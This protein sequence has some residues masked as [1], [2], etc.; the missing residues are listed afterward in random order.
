LKFGDNKLYEDYQNVISV[1]E[2]IYMSIHNYLMAKGKMP[3]FIFINPESKVRLDMFEDRVGLEIKK[4]IP[5]KLKV[6]RYMLQFSRP[7]LM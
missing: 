4:F 1:V 7:P 3:K 2:N 6:K 5:V